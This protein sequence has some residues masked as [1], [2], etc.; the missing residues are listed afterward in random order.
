MELSREQEAAQWIYAQVI[1]PF[2]VANQ[3][4][5]IA[6]LDDAT[7][8]DEPLVG[9]ADGDDPLFAELKTVI[10]PTHLTP[11]EALAAGLGKD[12]ADLPQ[13]LSVVS[14]ILPIS[15]ATRR[16]NRRCTRQPSRRWAYTRWYGEMFN[17]ALR[18]HV[19]HMLTDPGCP[20]VAP[21][22]ES[23]FAVE[24]ASTDPKAPYS[25]WSERHVAYAAGLGS[26]SLNDGLITERGIAHRCGSVVT[27]VPLPPSHRTPGL[28]SNCL[29]FATGKCMV[30]ATRCPVGAITE[31][32]HDKQ[33]CR[34]YTDREL[35]K[36]KKRYNVG[37][38]GCGLCQTGVPC[39]FHNPTR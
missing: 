39:E 30:C 5:R 34:E 7:I 33:K 25:N 12:A 16:S 11:R 32:G 4:N 28:R 22:L 18:R 9:I 27:T 10:A 6:G 13:R 38:A 29:H 17:E 2:V 19:V 23:Y 21:V 26:F 8:F 35:S 36:L 1:R 24:K 20:T 37:V 3:F 15:A 14:W 31:H